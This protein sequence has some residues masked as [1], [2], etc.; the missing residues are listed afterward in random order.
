MWYKVWYRV[1]QLA[2]GRYG[3]YR[4][5]DHSEVLT[6]TFKT[7]KSANSWVAYQKGV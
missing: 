4:C 6:K 1:R 7:E 2:N 3:V 5:T